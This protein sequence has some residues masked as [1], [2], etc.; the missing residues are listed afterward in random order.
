MLLKCVRQLCVNAT[1]SHLLPHIRICFSLIYRP[2]LIGAITRHTYKYIQLIRNGRYY[3]HIYIYIARVKARLGVRLAWLGCPTG[4]RAFRFGTSYI[5]VGR[6]AR[7]RSRL[8]EGQCPD[9]SGT[10]PCSCNKK[11]TARAVSLSR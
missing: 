11:C 1:A 4:Q 9:R 7:S 3:I 8:V 2:Y 5:K 6:R 10:T